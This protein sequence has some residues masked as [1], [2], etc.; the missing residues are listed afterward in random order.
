MKKLTKVLIS[1]LLVSVMMF[2]LYSFNTFAANTIISFS[3]NSVSVGDTVKV[4]IMR[5]VQDEYKQMEFEII[6]EERK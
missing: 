5:P 1:V 4:T 6:L 3:K 2:S